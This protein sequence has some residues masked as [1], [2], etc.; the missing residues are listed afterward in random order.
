MALHSEKRSIPPPVNPNADGIFARDAAKLA[1][2]GLRVFPL[3]PGRKT[4]AIKGGKGV[5]DATD[6][7]DVIA[8]WAD[9]YPN[10]NIGIACGGPQRLI[11]VDEDP[12]NGG[13]VNSLALRGYYFPQCPE[14][15]TG[16][17]GRHMYFTLPEG[18]VLSSFK[19]GIGIDIKA[20][21]G[22]VVA[23]PSVTGPSEAGPG[24]EYYWFRTREPWSIAA[25]PLPDWTIAALQ[26]PKRN[27]VPLLRSDSPQVAL[28][29]LDGLAAFVARTPSGSRNATLNWASF[30]AGRLVRDGHLDAAMAERILFSA[31]LA[32]GLPEAETRT[33][34]ARAL[35]A[36]SQKGSAQ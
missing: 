22:Y 3:A 35:R 11:V 21:G 30:T 36:A 9:E 20:A 34:I 33:T 27:V 12:R 23:A 16:N 6:D 26:P 8:R 25:P 15:R 17:G 13:S 5:H 24:G 28:R 31:G 10:G 2:I 29:R 4:P 14:A 19:L 7:L 32:C 18:V 1:A